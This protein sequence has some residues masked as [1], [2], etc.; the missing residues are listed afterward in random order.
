MPL[1]VK[2]TAVIIVAHQ[3]DDELKRL[4]T[5]VFIQDIGIENIEV[6][7]VDNLGLCTEAKKEFEG[8]VS[9][10]VS[11]DK[12][13][14]ASA[15]RNLAVSKVKSP[16]LFFFDDDGI[17]SPNF[18]SVMCQY[19][20]ENPNTVAARGKIVAL[21]HPILTCA[22]KH[23][24]LGDNI[25]E[26]NLNIEGATCIRR[27]NYEKVGGYNPNIFGHEGQ[28]LG[29]RLTENSNQKIVYIPQAIL[30]HDFFN[31]F[32][33]MKN[34]AKRMI[35]AESKSHID[36]ENIQL[37]VKKDILIDKRT[38]GKKVIGVFVNRIF[39]LMKFYY[40]ISLKF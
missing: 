37:S 26:T 40:K 25:I 32:A 35:I 30:Q 14:G 24:D 27:L 17:A 22:A 9:S 15:G 23:Y 8:K 19:F 3:R 16:Y 11:S 36:S 2:K 39:K 33:A 13:L 28:E 18:L 29:S 20:D 6:S 10:W 31:D 34:K 5:S 38:I 1:M 21:N 7:V 4:L 12:N